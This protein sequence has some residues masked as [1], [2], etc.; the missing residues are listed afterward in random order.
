MKKIFSAFLFFISN[1]HAQTEGPLVFDFVAGEAVHCHQTINKVL[2][3]MGKPLLEQDGIYRFEMGGNKEDYEHFK[4]AFSKLEDQ[5]KD[6]DKDLKK[7]LGEVNKYAPRGDDDNIRHQLT[8]KQKELEKCK[9]QDDCNQEKYSVLSR[10]R[11][12][13]KI[14]EEHIS[15]R[16]KNYQVKLEEAGEL[17]KNMHDILSSTNFTVY[18]NGDSSNKPILSVRT[19]GRT[20]RLM[21]KMPIEHGK[22][23]ELQIDPET[24][25]VKQSAGR[26]TNGHGPAQPQTTQQ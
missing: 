18:I 26:P 21:I 24:C 20:G 14:K 19:I 3:E 1:V 12:E 15:R 23:K 8:S 16:D 25:E 22:D 10:E 5:Y 9:K 6:A 2:S 7:I 11:R 17:K 4:I 13:L